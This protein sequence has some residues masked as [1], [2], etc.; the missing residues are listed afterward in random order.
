MNRLRTLR[1]GAF[2]CAVASLL[3]VGGVARAAAPDDPI[4][5][6]LQNGNAEWSDSFDAASVGAADVRTS[7]PTL[8]PDILAPMQAAIAQY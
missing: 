4:N 7:V 5:E 2:G 1:A 3:V 6:V 8:S